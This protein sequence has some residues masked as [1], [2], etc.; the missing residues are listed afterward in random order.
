MAML[1]YDT[2]AGASGTN[3]LNHAGEV[4]ASWAR[5]EAFPF[6]SG[7]A[8]NWLLSGTGAAY[9][10]MQ[11][12]GTAN[13]LVSGTPPEGG[14]DIRLRG[15]F[16]T[17]AGDQQYGITFRGSA[18]ADTCLR[19]IYETFT[20]S[21]RWRL[22]AVNS[23]VVTVLGTFSEAIA[24]DTLKDVF[25]EDRDEDGVTIH[26]DGTQRFT[27]TNTTRGG[28][29]IGLWAYGSTPSGLTTG[30]HVE[31][32][33]AGDP[34][35]S[36][37]AY[38]VTGATSGPPGFDSTDFTF[39]LSDGVD[40][41][42]LVITPSVVGW[43]GTFTP[44]TVTLTDADRSA[45][46]I[47]RPA[48]DATGAGTISFTND[49]SLVDAPPLTYAAIYAPPAREAY[50]ASQLSRRHSSGAAPYVAGTAYDL[51]AGEHY[52][53]ISA[54]QK[55]QDYAVAKGLAVADYSVQ[56]AAALT[57]YRDRAVRVAKRQ[58]IEEY[59]RN[60]TG[61]ARHY[62]E[63]G[64]ADASDLEALGYLNP[65]KSLS[66]YFDLY[67]HPGTV[68]EAAFILMACVDRDHA[69]LSENPLTNEAARTCLH[70]VDLLEIGPGRYGFAI[71]SFMYA[72][73][74]LAL[75]RFWAA[76]R[77]TT[78]PTRAALVARVPDAV[79]AVCD[80]LWDVCWY[81]PGPSHEYSPG[82]FWDRGAFA[83]R[84]MET[85]DPLFVPLTDLTIASVTSQRAVF[86]GP[87]SLSTVDDHY[88]D[89]ILIF[90]GHADFFA[91]GDYAGATREITIKPVYRPQFDLA[92]GDT[93]TM[94]SAI[95]DGTESHLPAPELSHMIAP[96]FA[97]CYW[98]ERIV[99]GDLE[100]AKPWRQKYH[101]IFDGC[102]Q[103]WNPAFSQ[104]V[105]NQDALWTTD[106]L[107]WAAAADAGGADPD[108]PPPVMRIFMYTLPSGAIWAVSV[109]QEATP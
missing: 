5:N 85:T 88:I 22:L 83:Y 75:T 106:G 52:D 16:K 93:F 87:A 34:G 6:V 26:I 33:A 82:A 68:R 91:V 102:F 89:A 109:P 56:I 97:W 108:P 41:G 7:K 18:T 65:V 17:N 67:A 50:W 81:P 80:Y 19:L 13:H 95:Y 45:T 20:S 49:G 10:T 35:F 54:F 71:K 78:D 94:R 84:D 14:H 74:M 73:N 103:S 40:P 79:K 55:V 61:I 62:V 99:L 92:P 36:V 86:R 69:G 2:F 77:H 72:L 43:S 90:D 57:R 42:T 29:R 1:S 37:P 46:C 38:T 44:P 107:G 101:D 4:G 53:P 24:A 31:L 12:Y 32:F 48:D 21:K 100:S 23:G 27:T 51:N 104:K 60:T 70:Q 64:H 105:Y 47:L 58:F 39:A 28:D 59:H 66:T 11:A 30:F 96:A 9:P 25:V 76:Y 8:N 98:H 63:G 3:L 15:R